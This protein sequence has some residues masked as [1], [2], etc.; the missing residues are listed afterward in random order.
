[1]WILVQI[2]VLPETMILTWVFL[3]IGFALAFLALLW[4]RQTGQVRLG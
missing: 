2:V 4:L 1:V 3:S